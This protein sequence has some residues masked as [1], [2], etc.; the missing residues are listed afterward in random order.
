MIDLS[1]QLYERGANGVP[2]STSLP[3]LRSRISSYTHTI[4][5][6]FGFESMSVSFV[7]TVDEAIDWLSNGLMRSVVVTDPDGRTVW[8]GY[9]HTVSA[10]VGQKSA[11]LSIDKMS[12]R[13]RCVYTTV[14][15]TPGTTAAQSD[16]DSQALYGKKDR[17]VTLD[18]SDATAALDRALI[19]LADVAYPKSDEAST[20]M[21]GELGEVNLQL[22]FE[23]WYGTL[24]WVLTSNATTSTASTTT[25]VGTLIGTFNAVNNFL[26]SSTANIISSGRSMTQFI[27]ANTTIREAI[28][29]RLSI[30]N[31]TYPL[32]WGVYEDRKFYVT[33]WA[34]A[35]PSTITYQESIATSHVYDS[36]GNIIPPWLVRPNAISQIIEL[37]DVGPV[38]S[39]PDAAARKYVGR[40]TCAISGD[41]VG[42]TLE[43]AQYDS[44][45]TRLA[46]LR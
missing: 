10:A 44:V 15:G 45:E 20:A 18:E 39:A 5:D 12:N 43:P 14:L 21:T 25:Q 26:S 19:V 30:G 6:R 1:V 27:A 40:V 16:T 23:G 33:A 37:L 8:E 17:V 46:S 22:D 3:E 4:T 32:A 42:V 28:E 11:V 41:Q 31:G 29:A 38:S 35:A 36:S 24:G 34:G 7:C 9:L 2:G 13:V